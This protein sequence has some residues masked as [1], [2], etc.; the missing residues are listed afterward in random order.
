MD[1][2]ISLL[3]RDELRYAFSS[4]VQHVRS[5]KNAPVD[6]EST[7]FEKHYYFFN[8]RNRPISKLDIR[9]GFFLNAPCCSVVPG[10]FVDFEA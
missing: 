5:Y 3:E 2:G 6:Q 4:L 1:F 9:L 8:C 7:Y 10:P